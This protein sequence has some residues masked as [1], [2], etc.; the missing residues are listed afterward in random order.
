M[1]I[2]ASQHRKGNEWH[3]LFKAA[4][5]ETD[6]WLIEKRIS[7]AEQAIVTRSREIF[8]QTG[9]DAVIERHVSNDAMYILRARKTALENKTAA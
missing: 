7:D 4:L 3:C 1:P 9:Q 6:S 2:P 5:L 8:R